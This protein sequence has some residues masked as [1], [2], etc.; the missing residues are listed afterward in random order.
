MGAML[1]RERGDGPSCCPPRHCLAALSMRHPVQSLV[2]QRDAE[3]LPMPS[4]VAPL[5]N[6]LPL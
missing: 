3:I 5:Q 2:M 4:F 6:D 1:G